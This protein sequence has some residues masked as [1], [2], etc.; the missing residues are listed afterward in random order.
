MG[1]SGLPEVFPRRGLLGLGGMLGMLGFR[2]GQDLNFVG[3]DEMF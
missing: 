2:Q 1:L 3:F